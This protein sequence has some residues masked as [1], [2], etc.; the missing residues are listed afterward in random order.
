MSRY[1]VAYSDF[2][3]RLDEIEALRLLAARA[4][5]VR[6]SPPHLVQAQAL[7]R[8]AVVLLSSHIEGYVEDLCTLILERIHTHRVE[9]GCFANAFLYYFSKDIIDGIKDTGD[10]AV[11]AAK[12]KGLIA[13][14][15][16]I[17]SDD[18]A[19]GSPLPSDRFVHGFAN[20]T[21]RDIKKLFNRFGYT[22]YYDD[23]A[24][25]LRQDTSACTNMVNHVVSQ[26]NKI[27]HGDRSVSGTPTDVANMVQYVRSYCR[28]TDDS[29]A[30]W[31]KRN[32]CTIR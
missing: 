12:V 1:T 4:T 20:P 9:K 21:V 13:R 8:G 22:N 32:K 30:N 11:L 16:D 2:L 27:A 5:R 29:V 14:D 3:A 10:P 23:V 24:R 31:L 25:I 18:V 6:A 19:F 7:Y 26:R 15:V 28:A 17:W